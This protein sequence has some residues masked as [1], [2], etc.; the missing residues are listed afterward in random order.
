MIVTTITDKEVRSVLRSDHKCTAVRNGS[1]I[2]IWYE[3]NGKQDW[4]RILPKDLERILAELSNSRDYE[5][6][7][8]VMLEYDVEITPEME[9]Q[10]MREEFGRELSEDEI[11]VAM[12]DAIKK[13][14]KRS[15]S[16]QS[17]KGKG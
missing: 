10:W 4:I 17:R 14:A 6:E 5:K 1:Y 13:V 9:R 3:K 11:K 15:K 12:E 8:E 16:R 2:E 7:V